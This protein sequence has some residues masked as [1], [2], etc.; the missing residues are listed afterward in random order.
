MGR[1]YDRPMTTR[2]RLLGTGAAVAILSGA[3]VILYFFQPW[4][5]CD[6]EDTSTGCA[7]LPHDAT[8]MLVAM[9]IFVTGLVVLTAGA[10]IRRTPAPGD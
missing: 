4:R 5:S 8:V 2:T 6:Y 10:L 1:E 7:M 3:V 9:L